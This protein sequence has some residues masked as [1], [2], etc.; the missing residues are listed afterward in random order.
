MVSDKLAIPMRIRCRY[1]HYSDLQNVEVGWW[2]G[3]TGNYINDLSI[4]I[5]QRVVTEVYYMITHSFEC[6]LYK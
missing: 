4:S 1:L 5:F 2:T 6:L 3:R